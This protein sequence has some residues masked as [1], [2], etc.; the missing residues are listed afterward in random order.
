MEKRCVIGIR[1]KNREENASELQKVL[2]ECGCY[3][4]TRLGL[5]DGDGQT[6]SPSGLILLE[7]V[8]DEKVY[9]QVE[10]KLK[11]VKNAQVQKM[12]FEA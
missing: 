6:C 7:I 11:A 1:I 5:H 9:D 2:T 4:K 3:I 8:G 12:V 10:K